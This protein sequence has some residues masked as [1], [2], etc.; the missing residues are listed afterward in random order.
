M[1][2][3]NKN[4]LIAGSAMK[5]QVSLVL[6]LLAATAQSQP[7]CS[8]VL[9]ALNLTEPGGMIAH[10]IHSLTVNTIRYYFDPNVTEN[11]GIPTVNLNRS[12]KNSL[13]PNAPL[14]NLPNSHSYGPFFSLDRVLS[15]LDSP[16]W[17]IKNANTLDMIAHDMHMHMMWQ[18]AS[19]KYKA[20][21]ANPPS[22]ATCS[23]LLN[24]YDQDIMANLNHIADQIRIPDQLMANAGG[25]GTVAADSRAARKCDC[26]YVYA[27]VII[28]YYIGRIEIRGKTSSN[29]GINQNNLYNSNIENEKS[30]E[31]WKHIMTEPYPGFMADITDNL[32]LYLYCKLN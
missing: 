23:C 16:N 10:G 14:V 5:A 1:G 12:D 32:A 11:N 22:N 30:W 9:D 4:T 19:E 18:G 6:L 27:G 17:G 7:T 13:F 26:H 3:Q 31:Q 20:L 15:H 24:T 25:N 21:V 28:V 2:T 8:Q 29:S